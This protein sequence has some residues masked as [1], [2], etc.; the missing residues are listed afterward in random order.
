MKQKTIYLSGLR[1]LIPE[2]SYHEFDL[3]E[4]KL[5][6]LGHIV[7]NPHVVCQD[8]ARH[9]FENDEEYLEQCMRLCMAEMVAFADTLVTLKDWELC[10][11][12]KKEVSIARALGF[13]SIEHIISFLANESNAN[14]ATASHKG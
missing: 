6:E 8:V 13:I 9:L 7:I 5:N 10:N 12:S 11:D 3:V 1:T 4:K 14:R 2:N